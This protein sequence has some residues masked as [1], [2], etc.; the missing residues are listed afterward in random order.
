MKGDFMWAI[1]QMKEGKKVRRENSYGV[2][3]LVNDI[4]MKNELGDDFSVSNINYFEATD[5]EIYE[6]DDDWNV[7]KEIK[8]VEEKSMKI[9]D[10][11]IPEISDIFKTFIQK[12]KEDYVKK[13]KGIRLRITEIDEIIDKRSGKI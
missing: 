3:H 2:Y 6:E 11:T 12:V 13:S 5:W 8:D 9:I 4:M 1:A 10:K 7:C